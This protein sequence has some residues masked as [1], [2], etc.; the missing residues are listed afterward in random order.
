MATAGRR[1]PIVLAVVGGVLTLLGAVAVVVGLVLVGDEVVDTF[2]DVI[3][4][5]DDL[6]VEVPVPGTDTFELEGGEEYTVFAIGDDLVRSSS[7]VDGFTDTDVRGFDEPD[8]VITAPGGDPRSYTKG[9]DP[10]AK[11]WLSPSAQGS[12]DGACRNTRRR[13]ARLWPPRSRPR[14]RCRRGGPRR[15]RASARSRPVLRSARRRYR[16]GCTR[17]RS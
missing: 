17:P 11:V 6:A 8:V 5:R 14:T 3:D 1:G 9:S 7:R 15:S 4:F 13:G 16:H 12:Y 10:Q 2:D